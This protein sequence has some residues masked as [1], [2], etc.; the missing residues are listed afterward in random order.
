V[1]SKNDDGT[2]AIDDNVLKNYSGK[3]V[4][5]ISSNQKV[6]VSYNW[7]NKIR[8]HR[9]DTPPNLVPDIAS[10][11]QTNPASSTQAK[12]TGIHNKTVFESS[13]S[14]MSGITSYN[15]QPNTPATA[16]RVVDTPA[17]SANFAAQRHEDQP[18]SRLQFDNSVSISKSGAGGDHLFKAGVQFAQLKYESNYDV[19]NGMY[20]NYNNGV[21]V[22]V[23]EFNTPADSLNRENVLG[24]FVQDAWTAGRHLTINLGV[25]FDHN[26]G[27]LPD[28][29]AP[30]GL[31]S[32]ARTVPYSEPIHQNLAVWRTGVVYDPLAD[33]STA[34]KAS[35]SRYGLQ[36]GIDRVTQVNPLT[37][38]SRTCPWTDPNKDGIAQASEIQT[39][40]CTAFPS[41][42]VHY[43][44]PNGPRWP[45][46]DEVT[47][48]IERQVI[49]DMRVGVM[50]YHRTNRD[51]VGVSNTALPASFY[52][53]IQVTIPN[54]PGGTVASPKPQTITVYNLSSASYLSLS[55]QTYDNQPFLD[56]TYNGVEFTANKRLSNRWQMVAGLTLGHNRGG[57]NT[58]GGTGQTAAT[59]GD[60]NDPNNTG[61]ANGI[62][63]NDSNWAFRL[64]GSYQFPWSLNFAATF[65]ANQGYPLVS[66][67]AVNR[68]LVPTLVRTTQTVFLSSRGDERYPDPKLL[69]VR[70]SRAF[71]FGGGRRIVPQIDI[72]N[73]GNSNAV[74]SLNTGVG[75]TYLVPNGIISPRIARVGVSVNF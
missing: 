49:K 30:G 70:L 19:L 3:G 28:Q 34:L 8:G 53:P 63:G 21:P 32:S 24:L 15:Y 48:G 75:G 39:A 54:G 14:I 51:Q 27:I 35:Y 5:S 13:F 16:V 61:Y 1:S 69:D 10:L 2:Q 4:F 62:I 59:T 52:T 66:T 26:T 12:Y 55:N 11:V 40:Q 42:T 71:N 18:N 23:Q 73:L 57:V 72:F 46:S 9:R 25:R 45:Y 22:N 56:T 74:T 47:A 64:S 36:V 7:N 44:G 43:A 37:V 65:V 68:T 50:Y 33:G 58:A 29:S 31:F 41:L 38:G 20:L 67:F 6:S 60:L 17:D